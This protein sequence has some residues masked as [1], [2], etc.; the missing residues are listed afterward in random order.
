[1][2]INDIIRACC[3]CR[4]IELEEGKIVE[5]TSELRAEL[6][7]R[8]LRIGHTYLSV[9]C[10]RTYFPEENPGEHGIKVGIDSDGKVTYQTCKTS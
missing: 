4:R 6:Q 2:A 5:E 7:N 3:I 10:W 9:E 1:M 8:G